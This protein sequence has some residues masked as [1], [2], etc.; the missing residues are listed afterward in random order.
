VSVGLAAAGVAVVGC[1]GGGK[2]SS[3]HS[4][5]CSILTELA[6]TG[7]TVAS[8]D[9]SDPA[10]FDRTLRAAVVR[11]VNTARRLREAVPEDLRPQV[12][13]IIAAVEQHDFNGA[14][15][16]RAKLDNYASANCKT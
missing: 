4:A 11:Y 15:A 7:Q 1:S 13:L 8:A 12:T 3:S 2:A 6:Q 16:A 9:V 14:S 5:P 10:A